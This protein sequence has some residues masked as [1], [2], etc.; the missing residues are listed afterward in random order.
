MTASSILLIC[1][2]CIP[3]F[4][5]FPCTVQVCMWYA[6]MYGQRNAMYHEAYNEELY[7]QAKMLN[8]IHL[9]STNQSNQSINQSINQIN[10]INQ[11]IYQMW[12]NVCL[13]QTTDTKTMN[14]FQRLFGN[15]DSG[16][17]YFLISFFS[18]TDNFFLL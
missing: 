17:T 2:F 12:M 14:S 5:Y 4:F 8:W 6:K 15:L 16:S 18:P 3:N 9:K 11:S 7:R 10:K 13:D 1:D